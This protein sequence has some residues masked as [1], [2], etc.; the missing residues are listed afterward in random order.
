MFLK[1]NVPSLYNAIG[2]CSFYAMIKTT[3]GKI[4]VPVRCFVYGTEGVGKT[5]FASGFPNPLFLATE[6]GTFH[7]DVTRAAGVRSFDDALKVL[8]ELARDRQGFETLVIDSI[9]WLESLIH[10]AVCKENGWDGIDEPK[11]GRGYAVASGKWATLLPKLVKVWQKG[12]HIVLVGHAR[13]E[14]VHNPIGDDYD[15]FS[16]KL[17]R[18]PLATFVEWCDDVLFATMAYKYTKTKEGK[19]LARDFDRVAYTQS[20]PGYVAKTRRGLPPRIPLDPNVY[21]KGGNA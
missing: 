11:F 7:V 16:P 21:L 3:K 5:V 4:K 12:M 6:S 9:D 19:E 13:M 2:G 17:H 10:Q 20:R 18:K 8:D 15:R 14:H 1:T